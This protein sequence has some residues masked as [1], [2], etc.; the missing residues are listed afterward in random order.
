MEHVKSTQ[1][2]GMLDSD[3]SACQ[4]S[5]L[6]WL[7]E[8][9]AKVPAQKGRFRVM[10]REVVSRE[11][12]GSAGDSVPRPAVMAG[13]LGREAATLTELRCSEAGLLS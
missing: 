2:N 3:H 8:L 5:R 11:G 13:G 12:V 10:N 4:L 9:S 6:S 7:P 1:S